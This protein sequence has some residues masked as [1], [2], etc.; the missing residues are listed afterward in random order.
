[1]G[2]KNHKRVTF[3]IQKE[4][5]VG[6]YSMTKNITLK[7]S[8]VAV[9]KEILET[10]TN[11]YIP[12]RFRG[13]NT[14]MGKAIFNSALPSGFR[15]IEGPVTKKIVNDLAPE[16][17][18]KYGEDK[19]RASMSKIAKIGFKFATI[20]SPTIT[21]DMIEIPDEIYRLKDKLKDSTPTE[22]DKLLKE[23][24]KI[25]KN[26][27]KDTGIYDLVESGAGKGWSQPMQILVA[28]GIISD[29]KGKIMDPIKGSFSEG[30]TNKEFFDASSGSRKGIVDRVLNTSSTGYFTRQLV[31]LL[32]PVEVDPYV[33]DCKTKRTIP[34]RLTNDLI[35]RLT[36]RNIIENGKVVSFKANDYKVG[37]TINLRSPIFCETPKICST[38]YG[39]LVKRHKSPYVGVLAA[40][41]LGERGTQL[42]MRTFHTGGAAT[43]ISRDILEDITRNDPLA[44]IDKKKLSKYLEQIDDKVGA[45]KPCKLS[46]DMSNYKQNDTI[47]IEEDHIWVRSLLSQIEFEDLVLSLILD[48]SA[49]LQKHKVTTVSKQAL[50]L[51]YDKGDIIFKVPLET[52]D[53]KS[54]INYMGRLVGGREIYKGPSHLLLK[55]YKVYQ[56]VS[57]MDLVHIE[58]LVSQAFRDKNSPEIPA[59]LGKTWDPIMVNLKTNVFNSGF[60]QGLAFEN[61][62]KALETG[63]ITEHDLSSSIMERVV[64]GE[65]I[66]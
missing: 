14:T 48:Y 55:I 25:L 26:H 60:V 17:I 4:M 47:Q 45:L 6:L 49:E 43:I 20:I 30:L 57:D 65:V 34:I 63:L 21:L 37:D 52:E 27:L 35:K 50:V 51:E 33:R 36:G 58:V 59:R 61:I 32:S 1:T 64:T 41:I 29:P 22:A 54:Q 53:I 23:M 44:E 7:Q 28:K 18:E 5:V 31:Y 19:A 16:L 39:D 56:K 11:P 42:I 9:T 66:K 40:T 13:K 15:F 12:V 24:E 2:S 62:N 3:E 10:A 46:I 8:P 38:C